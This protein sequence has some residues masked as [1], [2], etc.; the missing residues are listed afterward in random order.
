MPV[1][2]A[3]FS[4]AV[5]VVSA[6][7]NN[8][9]PP[10][11]TCTP[12]GSQ[13]PAGQRY[14]TTIEPSLSIWCYSQP[15]A[16][17]ATR[18]SGVNDWV[19]DFDND[20]PAIQQLNDRDYGYRR[21]DSTSSGRITVGY[22]VNMNHWM[23]DIADASSYSLDGGSL[24]SPDRVFHFE[25]GMLIVE[26][27][28]AA[29][30]D[31][32]QGADT[33]YEIDVSPARAPTGVTVDPLYGYGLFGGVGALGCRFERAL[34]GGH[35]VCAMYD[36]S[37]RDAGGTDVTGGPR[38]LP[39]RVWE[40][41]GIGST[42]TAPVVEGGYPQW[43]IP[44][45]QMRASDVWRQC[46]YNELDVHCRDRF[47]IELTRDNLRVFVNGFL[48]YHIDGLYA[49]NP[50]T[51]ADNRVPLSWQDSVAAYF[52]SWINSG[53]HHPTRWHWDRLAVNPHAPGGGFADPSAAPSFCLGLANNTC[54]D[55]MQ[56]MPPPVA[57]AT[58]APVQ[59]AAPTRTPVP[60]PPLG[61]L[62]VSFD[63]LPDSNHALI[64]AYPVGVI[65]W[66]PDATW[67]LSGPYDHFA[68]SSVSF[69][70]PSRT[71][72]TFTFLQPRRLVSI[73]A[74]NGGTTSS[75][76]TLRCVGQPDRVVPL[77]PGQT[78]TIQTGWTTTCSPVTI[79]STN[80]WST[81]FDNL[82]IE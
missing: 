31:A 52:T 66:G 4:L 8:I 68:T 65:D 22:F 15:P 35:I 82:R 79:D 76:V 57:T 43:P 60:T 14:P 2:A 61:P 40:A 53:I 36:N 23:P 13:V 37:T 9:P 26:A 30:S 67:Y 46:D 77:S 11:P 12:F 56:A 25:N 5:V 16:G 19:D 21:F 58:A 17:P 78:T 10:N 54:P 45:T 51:G 74:D 6:Q 27:D 38:G 59:V 44:G 73:D 71:S 72:G 34:D 81:N 41:Q 3:A 50:H 32:M 70:G 69:N 48:V 55:A 29:G 24:L 80:G 75:V 39:G 1:L 42:Y 28:M 63:N 62:T 20:G 18:S 33:F 64:G 47:R 7:Q 49:R